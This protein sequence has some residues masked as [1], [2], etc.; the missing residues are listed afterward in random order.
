[1]IKACDNLIRAAR[2]LRSQRLAPQPVKLKRSKTLSCKLAFNFRVFFPACPSKV[3]AL[4][5]STF[6]FFFTQRW[7]QRP[8]FAKLGR[9]RVQLPVRSRRFFQEQ[10]MSGLRHTVRVR[11][12]QRAIALTDA[13]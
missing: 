11:P 12:A 3:L 8:A 6:P 1:M 4:A 10:P 9:P 2:K 5:L 13:R 7:R